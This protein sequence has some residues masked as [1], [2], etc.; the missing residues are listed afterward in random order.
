MDLFSTEQSAFHFNL[1]GRPLGGCIHQQI[2]G[3]YGNA[4][5]HSNYY[6]S[7]EA[8]SRLPHHPPV[9]EIGQNV[10][11]Y[12]ALWSR[13]DLIFVYSTATPNALTAVSSSK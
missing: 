3:E 10:C 11:Y 7:E 9:D 1:K 4:I 6:I 2:C 5:F 13:F 8:V 12:S